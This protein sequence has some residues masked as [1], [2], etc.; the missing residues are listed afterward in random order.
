MNNKF[1]DTI[2]YGITYISTLIKI[3]DLTEMGV[4]VFRNYGELFTLSE[5]SF[6]C[7]GLECDQS[8]YVKWWMVRLSLCR[9]ILFFIRCTL[10]GTL[11]LV[12]F[13]IKELMSFLGTVNYYGKLDPQISKLGAPLDKLTW[14]GSTFHLVISLW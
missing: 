7:Q 3:Y 14:E 6:L 10:L 9:V 11:K 4:S 8:A 13:N 12:Y 5:W 1:L 2:F